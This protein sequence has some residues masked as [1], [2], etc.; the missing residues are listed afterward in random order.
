M[1]LA[2]KENYSWLLCWLFAS[3]W[4]ATVEVW[5]PPC[6]ELFLIRLETFS[7]NLIWTPNPTHDGEMEE[8]GQG[9]AVCP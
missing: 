5:D 8:D 1:L 4:M 6:V 9:E 2:T 3:P 7:L